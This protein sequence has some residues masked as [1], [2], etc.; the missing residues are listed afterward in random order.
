MGAVSYTVKKHGLGQTVADLKKYYLFEA[1][2]SKTNTITIAEL[3]TITKAKLIALDDGDDIDCTVLTN[4]ITITEDPCT[5]EKIV[6]L[7][8]GS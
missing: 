1:T 6:G 4:V 5:S 8:V 7:V 3:T 2:V